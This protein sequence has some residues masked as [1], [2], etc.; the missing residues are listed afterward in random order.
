M[1]RKRIAII[2]ARADDAEQ[3]EIIC[4]ITEAAFAAD[5]D[6][7]VYSNIYNHWVEDKQLN[8]ENIIYTLFEP[9]HFNGAVITAEA[10][11]DIS[12]ISCVIEKLRKEKLPTVVI[13]GELEGFYSVYSDD[14]YDMERITEHLITAHGYTD[15]DILTGYEDDPISQ[16]RAEGCKRAFRKHGIS[17]DDSKLHYGTFWNDSGEELAQRYIS[18][19]LPIPQAVIC[20]NDFMAYGLCDTLTEAG[21]AVP[22]RVA[23][24]GY[25][26]TGGR[27]YHYPLLTSYRRNRRKMG[28]DAVNILLDTDYHSYDTERLI[29]GGTCPCGAFQGQLAEELR[30]ERI[31]KYHTI[32]SNVA[33]FSSRLTLCRTLAEY[34]SVLS[35]F[36]YLLHDT[37]KLYLCLDSAWNS[38]GY[39]GNEF[40]CCEIDSNGAAAPLRYKQLLPSLDEERERPEIFYFSPLCF[41]TRLFGYTVLTYSYPTGYDF[42]FRDWIKTVSDTLEFLRMKN[43]IHYL[44]QCQRESSL[45]DTLTGFYNLNEF[46]QIVETIKEN[47]YIH[48]VKLSFA[49]DGE[50]I[51]GENYRNDIITDVVKAIK[52]ACSG[53]EICGRVY[54]DIFLVLCK[55][56]D[57]IFADR[58]RIMLHDMIFGRYDERQ[59]IISCVGAKTNSVEQICADVTKQNELDVSVLSEKK[60]LQHYNA[61]QDIRSEI[62]KAPEKA[63]T[64]SQAAKRL[65][66][67]EG[68]F[69]SVYK[70]CFD[71]SYNQDHINSKIMK[72]CYLLLTT[73]MS[74]FAVAKSCGYEDEKFFSRQFR[75]N[76]GCSP[77][78]FRKK[79]C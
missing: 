37:K 13:G 79:F 39:E 71:I 12:V 2:T 1:P 43:D 10:F 28:A 52:H 53:R 6:V 8:F 45:Y 63:P 22:E 75:Q 72:A 29:I 40:L 70:K 49:S 16:R 15:I 26:Y 5:A 60:S 77:I 51:Y 78:E 74:V 36:Y 9:C 56:D 64:L 24:T 4:G 55:G 31:G 66:V 61:L 18:G 73:A 38:A 14:E 62:M 34:T 46:R 21:I 48:A 67:S 17:F 41:Q 57:D 65:C 30:A 68:Y 33:Q 27:I 19:E 69:R 54:D 76:C 23:V 50:F 3:K 42:G 20:T 47:C 25:D 35:E 59:V 11:M 32:M 58:L 7:A 44:K